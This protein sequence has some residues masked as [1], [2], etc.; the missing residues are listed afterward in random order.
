MQ[1]K[2]N[3]E[4]RI[5]II[6]YNHSPG[7]H[8]IGASY[9]NVF[10][11][12]EVIL[13]NLRQ[14][15]YV[16]R[17]KISEQAIKELILLSGR[18][19]GSW[20]PGEL[21]KLMEHKNVVLLP[22]STYKRWYRKLPEAFRKNVERQ[23]GPP[24]NCTVMTHQRYFVL[25]VINLG[26]IIVA[27]QP[28]RGVSG[29]AWKLY[30]SHDVFPHHQYIAFYLWLKNEFHA[31]AVIHLGTH[32]TLEWLPGKE[33]GLGSTDPPQI[34]IQDLIDIYPYVVDDVGEGIQAKRRGYAVIID[35]L[36]PPIVKAGLYKSYTKLGTLISE[37]EACEN[38]DLKRE[39]LKEIKRLADKLNLTKALHLKNLD[40]RGLERLEHYLITLKEDLMPK[41][42]HTFGNSPDRKSAQEMAKLIDTSNAFEKIMKS[43]PNEIQSLIKAL[44]G[45]YVPPASGNDPI[46]NPESIPT[47]KNFYAFDPAKIPSK[48]AWSIAGKLV[49]NILQNYL[50][51][52][53]AYPRKVSIVL[54]ATE[55]IRNEGINEAQALWLIGMKPV[56]DQKGKVIGVEPIPALE[57]KRPRIDVV[58]HASGL[59]RDMFPDKLKLLDEAIRRVAIFERYKKLCV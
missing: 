30:H 38:E 6:Y 29:D 50:R 4:K 9:L 44:N 47:G 37:Y 22:I 28:Q 45:K 16:I 17:G 25:P 8:N 15:G 23:W 31:D 21:E 35:H 58:I 49:K 5:A 24:D 42:L 51:K 3:K 54:W 33:V 2:P 26:N 11:S 1:Q 52:H 41:G 12:L 48:Q 59:Y 10:R 53:K 19:V 36:T 7:K 27:P 57:L 34:L 40:E 14:R 55:T 43:G 39:K 13:N 20:A 18:N 46:V 56:W 32:G